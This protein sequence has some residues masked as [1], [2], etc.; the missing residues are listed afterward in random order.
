MLSIMTAGAQIELLIHPVSAV[1]ED[2]KVI[3]SLSASGMIAKMQA[4][5]FGRFSVFDDMI[6]S[7]LAM[8]NT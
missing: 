5:M 2:C 3:F 1:Q 7:L 8:P 6:G 4:S